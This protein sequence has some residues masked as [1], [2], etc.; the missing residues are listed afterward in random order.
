MGKEEEEKGTT[1]PRRTLPPMPL[2]SLPLLR[3]AARLYGGVAAAAPQ[4][5][6]SC[7]DTNFRLDQKSQPCKTS[8]LCPPCLSF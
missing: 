7:T 6:C 4:P 1:D 8:H 5:R 2:E 3:A